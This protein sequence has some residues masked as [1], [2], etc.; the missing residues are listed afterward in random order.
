MRRFLDIRVEASSDGVG[1][2]SQ[3][4]MGFLVR[5]S[6]VSDGPFEWQRATDTKVQRMSI[7]EF[8]GNFFFS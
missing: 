1:T 5:N 8:C 6:N 3:N 2:S 7:H 4:Q